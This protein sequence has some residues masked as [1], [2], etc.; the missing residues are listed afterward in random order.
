MKRKFS[1]PSILGKLT[2]EP[3]KILIQ[4]ENENF[5][6]RGKIPKNLLHGDIVFA[7]IL[8]KSENNRLA[9]VQI[10]KLHRRTENILL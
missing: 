10:L 3:S 1:I 5:F 6:V 2:F 9:E 4:T 7:K 8:K